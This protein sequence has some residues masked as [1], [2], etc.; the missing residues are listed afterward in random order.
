MSESPLH[1]T[2]LRVTELRVHPVKSMAGRTVPRAAVQPRGLV[3]D[4]SWMVTD[5]AGR[6]VTARTLHSLVSLEADTPATD[7]SLDR[8][9]RLRAP[10]LGEH[11]VD[12]PDG[13][14]S[15]VELFGH[16][17]TGVPAD[18]E[19]QTWLRRALGQQDLHLVWCARPDRR[20]LD[21]AYTRTGDHTAYADAYPVTVVSEESL[22]Q[23][24]DWITE[25]AL[26]RGE[27]PPA[28][29]GM[30]RFRPNVVVSGAGAFAEDDW[31]R[32]QVGEVTLRLVK[33]SPRCVL[34]TIDHQ[35]LRTGKEPI[36]T[37][38]RHRRDRAHGVVF[39][40]NAVPEGSGPIALGDPV[41]VLD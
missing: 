23:L 7:P 38:A 29:L 28:P 15:E 21:P 13:P 1:V 5:S 34:T 3:D 20:H 19:T 17:L 18:E 12:E 6:M 35:T 33:P 14:E 37:L 40:V 25:G 36:R 31:H 24:N 11:L 8:S 4:R 9:L 16:A 2:E 26:E 32:I 39:A 10:G 41:R 22:T 27:D 30:E